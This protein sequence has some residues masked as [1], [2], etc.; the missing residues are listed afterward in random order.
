MAENELVITLTLDDKA[1][2]EMLDALKKIDQGAKGVGNSSK[3]ATDGITA[4][5]REANHQLRDFRQ[6]MTVATIGFATII[7]LSQEWGKRNSETREALDNITISLKDISATIGSVLSPA[8]IGFSNLLKSSMGFFHELAQEIKREW[9]LMF[10]IITFGTQ[11]TVAFF[12]ALKA[13]SSVTDAWKDSI[14]TARMATQAMGE[15]FK[16]SMEQNIT[17]T[18][19]A[20]AKMKAIADKI[21]DVTLLYKS[22]QISASEYYNTIITAQD[23]VS[24]RNTLAVG[25]LQELAS[26]SKQIGDQTLMDAQ[27]Q[28]QEQIQL[29]NFY[30]QQYATAHQGMA[31][32]T[33]ALGKSIQT[34][35]STALSGI[36]TGTLTAKEAFNALGQAMIKTVVDFMVQKLVAFALEKTLL[37]G[38]VA[39]TS[40]AAIAIA[41]AWGPAAFLATVATLG[42]AAAQAPVS[43]AA[44]GSATAA[45][46]TGLGAAFKAGLSG[47]GAGGK[48]AEGTDTVPAMLSPGEMIFPRSMADAIRAGDISVS[49]RNGGGGGGDIEINLYGVTITGKESVRELAEE[50]GFEIDRQRRSARSNA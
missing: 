2:K 42:A 8:I 49:G 44:A 43:I 41:S 33:V 11:F 1:S 26:L 19:L 14:N 31:A 12:A 40:A 16:K 23:Q 50:L 30:K 25:Q 15:E 29:L 35:L 21:N 45:V 6:I 4:G 5:F 10:N 37:A 18:S 27:R 17:S 46:M 32:F 20:S 9:M 28:T 3:K 24:F 22:G 38:T 7:A 39:A 48:F 36:I 34:N 47:G 13:G